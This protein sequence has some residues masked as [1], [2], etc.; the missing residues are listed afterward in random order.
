M[1]KNSIGNVRKTILKRTN[2]VINENRKKEE[3]LKA[4]YTEL[5]HL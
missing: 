1:P 5:G 2:D 3:R 4:L